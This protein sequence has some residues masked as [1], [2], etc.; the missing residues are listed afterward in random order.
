MS[1]I[2]TFSICVWAWVRLCLYVCECVKVTRIKNMRSPNL[3]QRDV[4][5]QIYPHYCSEGRRLGLVAGF[6]ELCETICESLNFEF[7]HQPFVLKIGQNVRLQATKIMPGL[8][9][10]NAKTTLIE[11][12]ND[13]F[14]LIFG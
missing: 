5:P 1:Q 11:S 14:E 7:V 9:L 10:N 13:F 2:P 8:F 6:W 4:K 3:L 12:E